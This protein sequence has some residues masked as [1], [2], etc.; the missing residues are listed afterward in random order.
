MGGRAVYSTRLEAGRAERFRGFESHP[1]REMTIEEIVER[2]LEE[3]YDVHRMDEGVREYSRNMIREI[4]ERA[5]E[6]SKK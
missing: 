6:L 1:I 5:L 2:I 4:V 3:R